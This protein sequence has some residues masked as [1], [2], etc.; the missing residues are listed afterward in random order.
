VRRRRG[1]SLSAALLLA[2]V[3]TAAGCGGGGGG[4]GGPTVP[5]PGISF[6]AAGAAG[7]ESLSLA[8]GPGTS[9][10]TL[11]LQLRATQ[12]SDLY[13]VAFDLTYPTALLDYTSP[14]EGSFFGTPG[15]GQTSLQ[16][17]EASPGRLVVGLTRLG[18]VPGATGSGELLTLRFSAVGAGSQ[19]IAFSQNSAFDSAGQARPL[20]WVAGSVSVVR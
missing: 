1:R 4:G 8:A 12:V 14:T 6:V 5:T 20:T 9:P 11:E 16:V 15:A 18:A 10:T 2:A 3:G 13:G 7:A 17:A 19:G